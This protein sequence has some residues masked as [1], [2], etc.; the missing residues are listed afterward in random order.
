MKNVAVD[1]WQ[2]GKTAES[3]LAMRLIN[4]GFIGETKVS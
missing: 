4:P 1:H 2:G 3:E